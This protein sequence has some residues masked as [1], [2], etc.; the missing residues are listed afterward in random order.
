MRGSGK[1]YLGG[2]LLACLC[3]LAPGAQ[4]Q[5]RA[6]IQG[7][8]LDPQG[9]AVQGATVTV[10]SNETGVS[11]QATTDANGVYTVPALAPGKYMVIIEKQ[12]F[13]KKTLEDVQVA[14]EQMNSVNVT[15]EVGAVTEQVTVSASELPLLETSTGTISGTLTSRDVQ[16]LPSFGRDPFQLIRLAPGVFGDGAQGSGGG[17]VALP[18]SNQSSSGSLSSIFMTENQPQIVASGTRNNGNSYQI[19]GVEVNSLAWGGSAVI[20]PNEESVKEV[21]IQANP[22]SAEN[23][24]NS[25]AQVLVVSQNGTN[26]FH[27]SAFIKIHRP[28]L[29]A[30]QRW[31]G[32][33]GQPQR[34]ANR[35]NQIG[36]SFG[37]PIIK[38]HL[39]FFF[40]YETL[41]NNTVG[42]GTGW[43]E[44]PQFL[45]AVAS[46]GA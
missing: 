16:A 3:W 21:Q 2:M 24:R 22:Y 44:T 13:K 41:R 43:Y 28:G 5:Y 8:V 19:D 35:F 1:F 23:G 18:G 30:F 37:G 26:T 11:K 7:T 14:A 45:T 36:G 34:D 33:F 9:A 12:G 4:A 46:S 17:G 40:S 29:D 20:T 39:F 27:G 25:G 10:I 15:L 42:T 32:P 38:N 6:G 31:G